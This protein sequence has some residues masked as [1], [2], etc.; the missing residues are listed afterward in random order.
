MTIETI[1]IEPLTTPQFSDPVAARRYIDDPD[2]FYGHDYVFL[3]DSAWHALCEIAD[4]RG[5]TIDELCGD[6]DLIFAP[7]EDF[8][9][10]ARRYVLRYLE[11][12]PE[13]IELPANFRILTA[14]RGRRRAQ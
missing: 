12:I 4:E 3:E 14:L 11:Q 13:N 10:S 2:G 5:C 7:G 8:A 6:I 1:F 9:P